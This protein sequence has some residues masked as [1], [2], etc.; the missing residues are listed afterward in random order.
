M[1]DFAYLKKLE[2]YSLEDLEKFA[3]LIPDDYQDDQFEAVKF[4]IREKR[5][6]PPILNEAYYNIME[7]SSLEELKTYYYADNASEIHTEEENLTLAYLIR[8]REKEANNC[9]QYLDAKLQV[10]D[11]TPKPET[12]AKIFV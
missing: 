9:Q 4:L 10:L 6:E 12:D 3:R 5:G 8:M 1:V 2:T 7:D 11:V